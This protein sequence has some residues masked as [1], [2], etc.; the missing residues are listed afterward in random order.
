M[1]YDNAIAIEAYYEGQCGSVGKL[2]EV[3][4]K[5]REEISFAF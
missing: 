3:S 4:E 1:D 5:G 2:T